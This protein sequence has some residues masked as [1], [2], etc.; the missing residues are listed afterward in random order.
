MAQR[1][2]LYRIVSEDHVCPYGV[3]SLDLLKRKG[4][5]VS[6]KHLKSD[7]EAERFK[8]QHKVDSTPQTFIDGNRIGGYDDLQ[9]YFE[10]D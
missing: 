9:R 2:T 1:A 4:F 3:K 10:E 6:D 8:H 7:D 5:D